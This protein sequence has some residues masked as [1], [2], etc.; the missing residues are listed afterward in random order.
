MIM[1][2]RQPWR[3]DGLPH[4]PRS[5]DQAATRR[6]ATRARHEFGAATRAARR[7][8]GIKESADNLK[9]RR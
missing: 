5:R 7:P 3:K 9:V 2:K 1:F 6:D 4:A 8:I